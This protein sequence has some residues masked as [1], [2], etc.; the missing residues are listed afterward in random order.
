MLA[1]LFQAATDRVLSAAATTIVPLSL[2]TAALADG[3]DVR[4][5]FLASKAEP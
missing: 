3:D 5:R 1:A 2:A 4:A